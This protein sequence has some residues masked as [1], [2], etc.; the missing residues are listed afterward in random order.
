[1]NLLTKTGKLFDYY[2]GHCIPTGWQTV[3]SAFRIWRDLLRG[4]YSSYALLED[5]CPY[6]EC[7]N[8]FWFEL[9]SDET[10]SQEFLEY[11]RELIANVELKKERLTTFKSLNDIDDD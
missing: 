11:L 4:N 7:L 3:W 1:M 6:T 9:N 10:L 5:D 2:F 8:W